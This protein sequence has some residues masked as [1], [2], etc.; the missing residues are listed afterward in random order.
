MIELYITPINKIEESRISEIYKNRADK[1]MR[2]R[3]TDDRKRCIAGGLFI[4]RFLG[5]TK[6]I[7][8]KY[9]KPQTDNGMFFNLSHS[10]NYVLFALSDSPVGCDIEKLHNID[11]TRIAQRVFCRDEL[12]ELEKTNNQAEK[13]FELWTRKESLLK[14]IGEGFHHN[15]LTVDISKNCCTENGVIYYLKSFM[16]DN[17]SVSVCS[18]LAEAPS[19]PKLILL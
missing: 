7:T 4:K 18:S 11:T 5:D 14:C 12:D 16:Y 19:T 17:H 3:M 13:F 15:C 6:I 1:A 2:Y 10:G 8:G 9:G